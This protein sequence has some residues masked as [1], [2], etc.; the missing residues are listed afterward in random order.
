MTTP[1]ISD[2]HKVCIE[3]R[4]THGLIAEPSIMNLSCPKDCKVEATC[5]LN[6]K[7]W[8]I[9]PTESWAKRIALSHKLECRGFYI[10]LTQRYLCSFRVGYRYIIQTRCHGC[11]ID[12][13]NERVNRY[14]RRAKEAECED[15]NWIKG[16][17]GSCHFLCPKRSDFASS[18]YA[19]LCDLFVPQKEDYSPKCN[20]FMVWSGSENP[21]PSLDEM[22]KQHQDYLRSLEDD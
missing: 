11:K 3:H 22:K 6:P 13:S 5:P 9:S 8:E 19:P 21:W 20:A 2:R 10:Q 4:M 7:K 12:Q 17:S 18:T 14:E 1:E 15:C 16:Q